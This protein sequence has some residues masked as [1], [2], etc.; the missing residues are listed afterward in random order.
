MASQGERLLRNVEIA[1]TLRKAQDARAKR[2]E[3]DADWVIQR[4]VEN[5][6]A[7]RE[8]GDLA[9][10]NRALEMIGKNHGAFVDRVSTETGGINV[11]IIRPDR[12]KDNAA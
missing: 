4:L 1:A 5:H 7:A 2:T 6:Y 8:K 9:Q 12:S 11:T 10:S 3:T